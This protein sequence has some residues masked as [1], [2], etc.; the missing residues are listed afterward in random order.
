VA[1]LLPVREPKL[2]TDSTDDTDAKM[3]WTMDRELKP[4][5]TKGDPQ[6][7]E[8]IGA[9][10]EVHSHLGS[11]FLEPVYR[12][13]L[14]I[15]FGQRSIPFRREILL[16]LDY[17]GQQLR[18]GYRA[19]FVCYDSILVELKALEQIGGADRSQ[20]INYLRAAKLHRGLL[21]N[22]GTGQ[23]QFE[24]FVVGDAQA[25]AMQA[26]SSVSSVQSVDPLWSPTVELSPHRSSS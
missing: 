11:G 8:I 13:A 15:E 23:L 9:A 19:D 3:K 12:E 1:E 21:L 2:S 10:M 20:L 26:P 16:A 22:F 18:C 6:T 5:S 17:K 4:I 24:R 14:A 25:V 7:Y